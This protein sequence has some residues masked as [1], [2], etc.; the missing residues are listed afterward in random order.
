VPNQQHQHC[1]NL[2]RG[3][4][5]GN[6]DQADTVCGGESGVMGDKS[7]DW[8]RL[9][10]WTP[11]DGDEVLGYWQ[12]RDQIGRLTEGWNVLVRDDGDSDS[13]WLDPEGYQTEGFYTHFRRLTRPPEVEP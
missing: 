3:A 1:P 5:S 10:S 6:D 13:R 9:D 12:Y 8:L 7:D 4:L 2:G 11:E